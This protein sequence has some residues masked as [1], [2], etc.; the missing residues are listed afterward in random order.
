MGAAENI[1]APGGPNKTTAGKS[2]RPKFCCH[3][4]EHRAN[5]DLWLRLDEVLIG[6]GFITGFWE[7]MAEELLEKHGEGIAKHLLALRPNATVIAID[8]ELAREG[9]EI[10]R[11]IALEEES[12]EEDIWN[13]EDGSEESEERAVGVLGCLLQGLG[14][15]V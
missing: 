2:L 3:C 11:Q 14:F 4:V 9:A 13:E 7:A 8:A 6:E 12:E 5:P 10:W 1:P 15:R